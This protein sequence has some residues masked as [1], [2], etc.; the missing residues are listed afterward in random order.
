MEDE[1]HPCLI[2]DPQWTFYL[3]SYTFQLLDFLSLYWGSLCGAVSSASFTFFK[4]SISLALCR[5]LSQLLWSLSLP[6]S[7]SRAVSNAG[8]YGFFSPYIQVIHSCL[9]A[10]LIIFCWKLVISDNILIVVTLYANPLPGWLLFAWSFLSV[11]SDMAEARPITSISFAMC[12]FSY[13]CSDFL[14]HFPSCNLAV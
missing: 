2:P 11:V 6:S 13:S 7:P 10:H 12:S 14:P 9:F 4:A 5:Y 3:G 1:W 8:L